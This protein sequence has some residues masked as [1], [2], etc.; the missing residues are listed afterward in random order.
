MTKAVF[1]DFDG[2]LVDSVDVK[3]SAFMALYEAEGPAVVDRVRAYHLAH[4]GISRFAKL[5]HYETVLLGRPAD[6]VRLAALGDRF[7]QLV[8]AEVIAAPAI[9]GAVACLDR[10]VGRLPLFVVSGTPDEELRHIV[11]ARGWAGYFKA[12]AGSPRQK[13]DWLTTLCAEA[14]IPPDQG[15]MVGDAMTDFA[16]AR[17]IGMPFV[18][19]VATG[20]A[21]PFPPGTAIIGDLHPL[22]ERLLRSSPRT[23][24]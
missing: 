23:H 24:P 22:P 20:S 18:G 10:L 8:V 2:V 3:T 15:L 11:A 17:A 9:P 14:A 12:V 6:P 19:V 7:A 5:A 4:G 16:A 13:A 1:F 21:S